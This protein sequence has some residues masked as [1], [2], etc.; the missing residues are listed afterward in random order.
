[1]THNPPDDPV[2]ALLRGAGCVFAE[3]EAAIL[4]EHARDATELDDLCARRA[5][6]QPLEHLVGWVQFGNLRLSVGPGVFVPR[7]R[8]LLL[9]RTAVAAARARVSP[10][11]LEAFCG[12]APIAASV[13][14]AVPGVGLHVVDADDTALAFARRNL[15]GGSGIHLGAGL[16]PLP[17]HLRGRVDVIAA[18]PPY[19]PDSAR[20]LL[21]PEARD[22]EPPRALLGGPDGL[23]HVTALISAAREWLAVGGE[24]LVEMNTAQYDLIVRD[25]RAGPSY[26]CSAV[27][28]DD[29]QTAV[30][31]LRRTR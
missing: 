23:D 15:P 25:G 16:G 19:V 13:A 24:L 9:A 21:A 27:S 26:E 8:S 10:L 7:Q 31:R 14:N 11:V 18:V 6:G 4:R 22:H 12:V 28:G 20:G 29:G 2:V 17:T 5:S 1:M 30:A 3:Q